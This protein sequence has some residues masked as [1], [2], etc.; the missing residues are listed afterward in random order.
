MHVGNGIFVGDGGYELVLALGVASL[1]IAG[2]V[3]AGS[4]STPS[5]GRV[6]GAVRLLTVVYTHPEL[7]TAGSGCLLWPRE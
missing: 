7:A 5:S 3:R 6:A 1:L 4:A 2:V